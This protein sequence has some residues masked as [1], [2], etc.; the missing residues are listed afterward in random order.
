MLASCGIDL[1]VLWICVLEL[2][3]NATAHDADAIH[4]V[5]ERFRLVL[6]YVTAQEFNHGHLFIIA[7]LVVPVGSDLDY[8]TMSIG[9][10]RIDGQPILVQGIYTDTLD[11]V[12]RKIALQQELSLFTLLAPSPV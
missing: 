7:I 4:R 9:W 10:Q 1:E 12:P 5:N 11:Q 2:Q 3:C 8:R 6:Q